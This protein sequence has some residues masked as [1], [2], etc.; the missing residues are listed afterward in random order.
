[1]VLT[2]ID[3]LFMLNS[4]GMIGY[5]QRVFAK[6]LLPPVAVLSAHPMIRYPSE[7]SDPGHILELFETADKGRNT[8]AVAKTLGIGTNRI[9]LM[10]DSGGDG[11]HFQWGSKVGAYLVGSMT[12]ASLD[13][14]CTQNNIRIH[15]RFGIDF[16]RPK[17][18]KR[19]S[20]ENY[21]FLDLRHAIME[22]LA[23]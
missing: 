6:K 19:Q 13:S 16:S 2:R 17:S 15:Q 18:N 1:M 7:E 14:Y 21:N 8:A 10:G 22:H 20:A 4:T 11:P 9:I 5:F 3:I 23:I 12:K